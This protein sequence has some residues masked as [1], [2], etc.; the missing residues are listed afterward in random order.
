MLW[1]YLKYPRTLDELNLVPARRFRPGVS[2]ARLV[3]LP[4]VP[5]PS[6][7]HIQTGSPICQGGP[8]TSGRRIRQIHVSIGSLI[9]QGGPATSGYVP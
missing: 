8:A 7:I 3:T 6:Q 5:A 2:S 9:R 1:C 4:L